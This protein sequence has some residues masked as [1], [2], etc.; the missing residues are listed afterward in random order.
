MSILENQTLTHEQVTL[1]WAQLRSRLEAEITRIYG[2]IGSYPTPIAGCDQQFNYLL[3]EQRRILRELA[4]LEE[5][6]KAS[7][8]AGDPQGLI[9]EFIR[10]SGYN[11]SY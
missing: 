1:P 10:S 7:L 9:D 2:E 3:E 11:L 8:T 4:R 6:A 5:V